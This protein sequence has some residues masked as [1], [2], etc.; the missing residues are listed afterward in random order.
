MRA[1]CDSDSEQC[2]NIQYLPDDGGFYPKCFSCIRV[3]E[4]VAL[5]ELTKPLILTML[6][7]WLNHFT[8]KKQQRPERGSRIIIYNW[9]SVQFWS[10]PT[11]LCKLLCVKQTSGNDASV[12]MFDQ[13]ELSLSFSICSMGRRRCVQIAWTLIFRTSTSPSWTPVTSTA[14]TASASCS[15]ATISRQM[16]RRPLSTTVRQTSSSRWGFITR[17]KYFKTD[18]VIRLATHCCEAVE[19][20]QDAAESLCNITSKVQLQSLYYHLSISYEHFKFNPQFGS[21]KLYFSRKTWVSV[22][23]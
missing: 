19:L 17:T 21:L 3:L 22:A 4:K 14:S 23:V 18:V 2:N 13:R 8:E 10:A 15:G 7:L 6:P 5:G 1:P 11:L 12:P 20:H 16:C 9:S